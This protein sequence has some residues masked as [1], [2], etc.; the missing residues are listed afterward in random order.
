MCACVCVCVC[1]YVCVFVCV[2]VRQLF[3]YEALGLA[4]EGEGG[5]MVS[6]GRWERQRAGAEM[7]V[8]TGAEGGSHIVNP[9]GGLEAKGHPIGAT[10]LAQCCEL[11]LQV[12][13]TVCDD[14]M[15]LL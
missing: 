12:R 4:R 2:S 1:V 3:M 6:G 7:F 9:S 13:C 10:G 14:V 11:N 5:A 15:A 8:M